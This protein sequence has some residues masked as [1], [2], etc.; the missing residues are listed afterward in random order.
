MKVST[1]IKG[2]EAIYRMANPD[3]Y[4]TPVA[5]TV[6][7]HARLQANTASNRAPV[8]SGNLAGSIPPSVKAFNGDK[9]GWSY[10]SEVEYAAV[11]EYTH[12][13]KKGFM[14]KTMFEGEQ[15]LV[16]DLEKTVQRI[17]RGL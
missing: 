7:K 12:K 8:E 15:P 14:R 9:T 6:E 17:A 5:N 3:R 1:R 16:S 4:K 13:T 10:G 2:M 11:Q